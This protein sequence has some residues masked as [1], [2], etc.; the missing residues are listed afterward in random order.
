LKKIK[1][2]HSFSHNLEAEFQQMFDEVWANV[3]ENFYDETFHGVDWEKVGKHFRAFLPHVANR[4]NLRM[5]FGDML[6]ELNSSHLGFRSRGA[7]EKTFFKF[8]TI[9]T[10]IMFEDEAPYTVKSIVRDSSAHRYSISIKPGDVLVKVNGK[11]VDPSVNREKYFTAPEV[12]DE[13]ALTFKRGEA[14]FIPV[15]IHPHKNFFQM[16]AKLYDEWI[17]ANRQRVHSLSDSKIGYVHMKNMGEGELKKFLQ[18]MVT[19]GMGK[20]GL[21]LDLRYNTGGNVHDAVLNFLS[22]RPYTLW[23][24]RGGS[25]APQPHFAPS[26]HPIVLLVNQQSLSDAEM[27]T[28]G[29]KALKLGTIIGTETY[30]WVIFTTGKR[31][32]D[33]S[34]YRLPSWGCYTLDKRDIELTGVAPDIFVKNTFKHRIDGEDPQL[35]RAVAHILGLNKKK[36]DTN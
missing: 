34:Y 1:I 27:T 16:R 35:K 19:E 10:G 22:Q 28:A 9:A 14:M 33:G 15:K 30:R 36:S 6:G 2:S 3:Q 5:I 18:E 13:I 29:F 32:V 8:S 24:Y 21:I 11:A 31:L 26:Q 25:Y 23:K 20:Q 17:E 12:P 4:G 7:E